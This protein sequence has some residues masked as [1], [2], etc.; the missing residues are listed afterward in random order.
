MVLSLRLSL[1]LNVH[2]AKSTAQRAY[3][4]AALYSTKS[5]YSP[6]LFC[7]FMNDWESEMVLRNFI[8]A[9]PLMRMIGDF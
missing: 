8:M 7:L 6:A 3:S 5:R 4:C 9:L 2:H 1:S